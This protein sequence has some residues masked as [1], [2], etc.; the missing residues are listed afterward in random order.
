MSECA[1]NAR[2]DGRASYS[3]MMKDEQVGIPTVSV[4][5][6]FFAP[7]MY[8]H[9]AEVEVSGSAF[10]LLS[11]KSLRECP[12]DARR[13]GRVAFKRGSEGVAV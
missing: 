2:S 6:E 9:E 3:Q 7:L 11:A 4:R 12:H 1:D 10:A 5:A 13:D 8:G